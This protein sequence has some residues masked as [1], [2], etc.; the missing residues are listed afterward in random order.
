MKDKSRQ[1]NSPEVDQKLTEVTVLKQ[2]LADAQGFFEKKEIQLKLNQAAKELLELLKV[3]SL[4][5]PMLK[6]T[7]KQK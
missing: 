4:D 3:S 6:L 1:P 7:G 2:Q 5:S